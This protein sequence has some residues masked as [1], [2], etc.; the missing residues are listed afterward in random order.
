M[1][2]NKDNVML[3]DIQYVR[4]DNRT[5]TPDYLYIIWQDLLTGDKK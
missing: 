4:G 3:L 5:K 1:K 2:M